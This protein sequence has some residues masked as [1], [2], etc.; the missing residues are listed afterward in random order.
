MAGEL[1]YD[2]APWPKGDAVKAAALGS[3]QQPNDTRTISRIERRDCS[4]LNEATSVPAQN[5]TLRAQ[6]IAMNLDPRRMIEKRK[7]D[8]WNIRTKRETV[9]AVCRN[10]DLV[11]ATLAGAEGST[12]GAA[13]LVE[14]ESD[15]SI[16]HSAFAEVVGEQGLRF[17]WRST[18]RLPAPERVPYFGWQFFDMSGRRDIDMRNATT[19]MGERRKPYRS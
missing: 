18:R 6:Y 3:Q 1:E 9:C 12:I 11:Q 8:V 7:S 14:V 15:E 4:L 10:I 19:S 16:P 17:Q 2:I 5:T 13:Q